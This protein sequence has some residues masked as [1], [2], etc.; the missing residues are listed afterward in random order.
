MA[1]V[2]IHRFGDE[3]GLSVTGVGGE[4]VYL[5][6]GEALKLAKGIRKAALS[7]KSEPFTTSAGLNLTVA[8]RKFGE[9]I[10]GAKTC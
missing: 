9:P 10:K 6:P 8:A 2:A 4:T 3:V 1:K 7:C 5:Q